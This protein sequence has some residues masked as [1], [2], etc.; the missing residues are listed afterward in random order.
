MTKKLKP[1]YK[2]TAS[3]LNSWGYLWTCNPDYAVEARDSFVKTLQRIRS[4]PNIY[5]LRGIEFEKQCVAGKVPFISE[6]IEGGAFQ[7][8]G[9]KYLE[10]LDYDV[11]LLGY[12][13]VLKE[14]TIYD[15][16]RVSK[17]D[18]QKYF[19][20]YQHSA[21]FALVPEAFE[22][23]YLIGAGNND[24][25]LD[26]FTEKYTRE[27][28]EKI[29]DVIKRFYKWLE[30]NELLNLYKKHWEIEREKEN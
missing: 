10:V 12:L 2:V 6:V 17:Y 14:G 21:Y 25:Y 28:T 15:V 20:S 8:Y 16:K 9:E 29:E 23:I 3:L 18:L 22:F 13:D 11:K 24:R 7:V 19:D 30:E 26:V 27:E 4:A 1:L 5:M